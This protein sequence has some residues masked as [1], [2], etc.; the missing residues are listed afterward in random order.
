MV[1]HARLL[2]VVA[3]SCVAAL[4]VVLQG[5]SGL[6]GG[7]RRVALEH[8]LPDGFGSLPEPA[9]RQAPPEPP[10]QLSPP[11]PPPPHELPPLPSRSASRPPSHSAHSTQPSPSHAPPSAAAVSLPDGGE[12][13]TMHYHLIKPQALASGRPDCRPLQ[14][15]H[16]NILDG[17]GSRL[18]GIGDVVRTGG[19]DLV[20]LNELNG[21]NEGRLSQLGREW[22]FEHAKLLRK[23]P[24]HIG[25][26]SKHPLRLLATVT[27]SQFAHGLLCV[28]VL[29]MTVCLTHLNPH[30]VRRRLGE[31][32]AIAQRVPR[33]RPFLL[34]GDLN[35][36]SGLDRAAHE[37]VTL[38]QVIRDGPHAAALS[39]KFLSGGRGS[40]DYSPM[41]A[42]LDA[43]LHDVGAESGPTVPTRINADKMHFAQLRLDY[44]LVNERL[45]AACGEQGKRLRA[46]VLRDERCHGLSDHFPVS[47]SFALPV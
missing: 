22:G 6:G 43:P 21:I 3:L 12:S 7:T 29:N 15:L 27:G 23:S 11:P 26:L 25:L 33:D 10:R 2:A 31:A 39:K 24:Y 16:W 8:W 14:L 28:E 45:H 47:L 20:S 46:V 9:A 44:V 4:T 34:A 37:S 1:A 40:I 38:A 36:L 41:Q 42:L 32:R 18:S 5:W 30:D 19:Y 13:H 35:T 17:G